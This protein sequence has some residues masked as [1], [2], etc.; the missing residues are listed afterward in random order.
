MRFFSRRIHKAVSALDTVHISEKKGIRYLHLGDDTV[1]SAMRIAAPNK[2]ELSYTQ[3][4]MG[5]LLFNDTPSN[6]LLIGLGGGSI[7]KFLLHHCPEMHISAVDNHPEMIKAAY[8]YFEV[9]PDEPRLQI[10][11]ADAVEQIKQHQQQDL[12]LLDGFDASSQVPALATESFYTQ[13]REALSHSGIVS[14]NLW[15]SDPLF[16]QYRHRIAQ[17]FDHRIINLPAERYG[18]VIVLAF[19]STPQHCNLKD[20]NIHAEKLEARLQLPFVR[21]LD[22]MLPS[23]HWLLK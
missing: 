5:C 11:Q 9:P 14:I 13:C 2:L 3:A 4:M 6:A 10:I 7:A 23:A 22:I 12:I 21:F 20:L 15:G 8:Q 16:T 17:V 19:N 1:Q 18:N